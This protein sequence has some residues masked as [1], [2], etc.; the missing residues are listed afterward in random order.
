[1][2]AKKFSPVRECEAAGMT[3][4]RQFSNPF[5]TKWN[6]YRTSAVFSATEAQANKLIA[7]A[8]TFGLKCEETKIT[9]DET[10]WV[11]IS[12]YTLTDGTR[13]AELN[14]RS[15]KA[16]AQYSGSLYD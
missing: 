16:R 15:P 7:V 13:S 12:Y 9:V 1:M 5:A 2:A 3:R 14:I 8:K 4:Q 11:D 10:K 6:D